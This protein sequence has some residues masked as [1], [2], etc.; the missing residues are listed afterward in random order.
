LAN[1]L[2]SGYFGSG[3]IGDDAILLGLV[4]GLGNT[5]HNVEVLSGSPEETNRLYGLRASHRREMD[6]VKDAMDRCDALVFPGGSIFQDVTSVGSV[7]YYADLVKLA[8]AKKKRVILLGQGVGPL[9]SFFGKRMAANAFNMADVIAVRDPQSAATLKELGVKLQPRITADSAFLLPPP[10]EN[11]NQQGFNVG[12]MKSVGISVRPHGKDKSVIKLFGELTRLLFQNNFMPVLIELDRHADGPLILEI[13]KQQGGKIP[14]LRKLTTPMALQQRL[15]RMDALI[16]MRLHAGILAATV[17]LPPLMVSYDP[18]VTA[19]AQLLD[20]GTAPSVEGLTA[21]R[22]YDMF[23]EHQRNRER[24][25]KIMERK[26]A[27][28]RKKAMQ[29]VELLEATVR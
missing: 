22:L 8:K 10:P 20:V 26:M 27:E 13:A 16:A 5:Q 7:K 25:E 1:L 2:M 3:N 18:K 6:Q 15:A 9:T 4:Q 28:L 11:D 12:N 24:N 19:F 29:N 14:D 21:Q 17:G 23:I